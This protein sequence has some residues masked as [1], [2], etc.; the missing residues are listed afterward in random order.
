MRRRRNGKQLRP[1][2]RISPTG[3]TNNYR[4]RSVRKFRR[5]DSGQISAEAFTWGA[6]QAEGVAKTNSVISESHG[7]AHRCASELNS[8]L[9]TIAEEGKVRNQSDSAIQGFASGEIGQNQWKW[10]CVAN[11][12]R[13]LRRRPAL[14]T[15]SRPCKT[16]WTSEEYHMS[17]RQFAQQ[18]GIDTTRML[19]SPNKETIAEQ[20]KAFSAAVRVRRNF[21]TPDNDR[22]W[23]SEILTGG[24]APAAACHALTNTP[25]TGNLT[26]AAPCPRQAAIQPPSRKSVTTHFRQ[27][28]GIGAP[29]SHHPRSV[30][31]Q[32]AACRM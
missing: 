3:C 28:A 27:P 25:A 6:D 10:S 26:Q 4:D 32:Q 14:R 29:Q 7:S 22:P 24:S 23:R 15:S 5:D 18:H 13:I 8:R 12:T 21:Q 19:G 31:Q 9:K 30:A 2:G 11:R 17:A 1:A 16:Y 20:V